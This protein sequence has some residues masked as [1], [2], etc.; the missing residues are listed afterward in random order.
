MCLRWSSVESVR[1]YSRINR[2]K[3]ARYVEL[4]STTCALTA[5]QFN[6]IQFFVT[7]DNDPNTASTPASVS[8]SN[9]GSFE[10]PT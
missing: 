10:T 4:G 3:Y 9:R 2:H 1:T 7:R 6:S 8:R 5:E